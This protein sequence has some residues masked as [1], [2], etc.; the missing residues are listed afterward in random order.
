MAVNQCLP[1]L[2]VSSQEEKNVL[3]H[4]ILEL[5]EKKVV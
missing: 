4:R 3:E 5:A 1:D 2:E